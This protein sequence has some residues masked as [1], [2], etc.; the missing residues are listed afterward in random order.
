MQ[1]MH[2]IFSGVLCV[3]LSASA[4][5][6][7]SARLWLV[8]DVQAQVHELTPGGSL[9]ASFATV[10][11]AKSSIALD[12][13]DNTLWGASEGHD[14]IVNYDK[15][16]QLISFF[17]SSTFDP[18]ALQPE[19]VDVNPGDGTLW[20]VDDFTLLVYNVQKDGTLISSL[21][22][23]VLRPARHEPARD[24]VRRDR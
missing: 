20:I 4:W 6:Q 13:L 16:G 18:N 14:R 1:A 19:G 5:A 12:P 3:L 23:V 15:T 8:D 7:G 21:P 17:P 11:G 24:S 2:T 10:A 22:H 9:V